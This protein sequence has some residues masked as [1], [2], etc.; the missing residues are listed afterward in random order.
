MDL[1]IKLIKDVSTLKR[2]RHFWLNRTNRLREHLKSDFQI[3]VFLVI[4]IIVVIELVNAWKQ[5]SNVTWA[6]SRKW[7]NLKMILSE[8]LH[9]AFREILL[10]SSN[11]LCNWRDR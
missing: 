5:N 1:F 7:Q 11:F 4:T 8:N 10:P 3:E 9:Q 2:Y 6:S